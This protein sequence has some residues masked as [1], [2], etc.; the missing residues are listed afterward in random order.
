MNIPQ[1]RIYYVTLRAP[2][3]SDVVTNQ[4]VRFPGKPSYFIAMNN[5]GFKK[6]WESD[7]SAVYSQVSC[8]DLYSIS[9]DVND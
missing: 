1:S 3:G 8:F 7:T 4:S 2:D 5:L 6:I 9:V